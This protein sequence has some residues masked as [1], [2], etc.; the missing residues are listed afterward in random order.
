MPSTPTRSIAMTAQRLESDMSLKVR[1]TFELTD[2]Q[3]IE[4]VA[5]SLAAGYRRRVEARTIRRWVSNICSAFGHQWD[6][7]RDI[8]MPTPSD[9]NYADAVSAL[10]RTGLLDE[11]PSWLEM[12]EENK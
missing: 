4:V 9:Q 12:K 3:L 5:S 2:N 8:G 10:Q 7:A 1:V 6:E 11:W